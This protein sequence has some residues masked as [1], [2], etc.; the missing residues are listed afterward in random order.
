MG[1]PQPGTAQPGT[2]Q[3][4]HCRAPSTPLPAAVRGL[5][6]PG[7]AQGDVQ[8]ERGALSPAPW[9]LLSWESAA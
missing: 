1:I 9:M 8:G 2:A 5:G 7:W 6:P 4:G 3:P